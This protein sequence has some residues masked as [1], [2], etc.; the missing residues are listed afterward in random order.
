[1]VNA[2]TTIA[3]PDPQAIGPF[4]LSLFLP[5]ALFVL[6]GCAA[7]VFFTVFGRRGRRASALFGGSLLPLFGILI[8]V[9]AVLS[10]ILGVATGSYLFT[11]FGLT[12][13]GGASFI[14]QP[15]EMSVIAIFAGLTL[16]GISRRR[17]RG[18]K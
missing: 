5:I 2:T 4:L 15:W 16:I 11:G 8:L 7:Y 10:F 3:N 9:V 13:P 1:M 17:H 6:L 18:R 12:F 14:I